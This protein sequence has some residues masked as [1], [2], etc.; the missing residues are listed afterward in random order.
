MTF[1][2]VIIVG[3]V[4]VMLE[5]IAGYI[6]LTYRGNSDNP[7]PALTFTPVA[8]PPVTAV[9]NKALLALRTDQ[10]MTK[11]G[12]NITV[13]AVLE[14]NGNTASA[15]DLTIRYD[16]TVLTLI[17]T[18]SAKPFQESPIFQKTVFNSL[19]AKAGIATMSAVSESEQPVPD[20]AFLTSMVFKALKV[21]PAEITIVFTPGDTRDTNIVSETKDILG[22][23]ENLSFTVS[24]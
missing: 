16:P 15:A 21:G 19:D 5:S 13:H 9:E 23:V 24:P 1:K 7:L 12:Q 10:V 18:A 14:P 2:Q 8:T 6:Y 17:A 22:T 20:L 11:K 4:V 3:L